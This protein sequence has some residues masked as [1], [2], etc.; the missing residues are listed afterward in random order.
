MNWY[1]DRAFWIDMILSA[2]IGCSLFFLQPFLSDVL[3]VPS[4]NN[5]DKIGASLISIGATLIGF[6]LTI[7]TV[8]ITFKKGF[9]DHSTPKSTESIV[10]YIEVP[11]KTIFG[12]TSSKEEQ[13]YGTA[14]HNQV[15]KV[16]IGATYEVGIAIF[17][18]LILQFNLF[19][20]SLLSFSIMTLLCLILITL[21]TIRSIHIF[22]HYL[23]IHVGNVETHSKK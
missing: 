14:I 6:L 12:R 5:I 23:N 7:I 18:L 2:I 15:T 4:E 21:S 17:T 3:N 9:E 16:F 10:E 22:K 8:I 19:E 1:L 11:T 13:F 20:F